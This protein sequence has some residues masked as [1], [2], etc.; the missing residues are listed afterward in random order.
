VKNKIIPNL[1]T[2]SFIIMVNRHFHIKKTDKILI[3]SP[4]KKERLQYLW[5]HTAPSKNPLFYY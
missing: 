3:K 5:R 2:P 1:T 4:L